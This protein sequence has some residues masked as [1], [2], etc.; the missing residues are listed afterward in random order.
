MTTY[1]NGT[2]GQHFYGFDQPLT[3]LNFDHIGTG[4]HNRC[5]VFKGL[6]RRGIRHKRQV[7]QQQAVWRTTTYGGSVVGDI[8]NGHRQ[9]GVV[10]LN[11]HAQRVAYQH[12]VK[13]FISK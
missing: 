6:F 1:R 12:D 3:A 11:R 2:F 5:G 9:G 10:T 4:T 13:S 8:G 7:S